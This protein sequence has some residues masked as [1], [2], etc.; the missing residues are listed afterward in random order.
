[1][2]G[3]YAAYVGYAL[4]MIEESD[5]TAR[6]L[7]RAVAARLERVRAEA[8]EQRHREFEDVVA[9][10]STSDFDR[11]YLQRI[12]ESGNEHPHT[13][14]REVLDALVAESMSGDWFEGRRFLELSGYRWDV[15]RIFVMKLTGVVNN[16]VAGED[17]DFPWEAVEQL[18]R[19][20][21]LL[22]IGDGLNGD[23]PAS[24][25]AVLGSG[26][27]LGSPDEGFTAELLVREASPHSGQTAEPAQ[28]TETGRG[29]Q[30][31]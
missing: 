14:G 3:T 18:V 17:K 15:W 9:D 13:G 19:F 11:R 23:G 30:R 31:G 25:D 27:P 2:R 29:T 4:R 28:A 5:G 26:P 12:Y 24:V 10:P 16:Q 7:D 6:P 20:G 1:M 22:R 21:Y 8:P